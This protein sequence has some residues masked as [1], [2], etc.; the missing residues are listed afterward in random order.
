MGGGGSNG[1]RDSS[2]V[3]CAKLWRMHQLCLAPDGGFKGVEDLE[4]MGSAC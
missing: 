3:Q 2:S 4:L 1:G